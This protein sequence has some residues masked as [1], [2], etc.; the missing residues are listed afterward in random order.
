MGARPIFITEGDPSGISSQLIAK[1]D[2]L[3]RKISKSRPIFLVRSKSNISYSFPEHNV[4]LDSSVDS[5]FIPSSG[6]FQI[7]AEA[8]LQN[9]L[10]IK[11]PSHQSDF[12]LKPITDRKIELGQP[13]KTT[14][15]MS[16]YSLL[17][18]MSLVE[19]FNGDL[20]TLPLSKEWVI[21]S[22]IA[23]FRGHTEALA[24]FF[25]RPTF[26][27]M[28][29][30]KWNVIPLTTHIPIS[31]VSS[32]LKLVAWRKLFQSIIDSKLFPKAC[33][34]GFM[35]LNPHAGEGGKVGDEERKVLKPAMKLAAKMGFQVDGPLPAD[36]TFHLSNQSEW[37]IL[38]A[39]YHDQ[40]LI[41]F[42]LLE[43]KAGINVTLGLPFSRV[44]PDHGP[45][46]SIAA[47]KSKVD[48]LSLNQCLRWLQK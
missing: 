37:D 22:G 16:Y 34:L 32:E 44:S 25:H 40:G 5:S 21:K 42:K 14:G 28:A 43:G 29:G 1:E 3:L 2:S 10:K 48:S 41:P 11:K 18:G 8:F 23:K 45:A 46:Y 26:M 24:E 13:S 27:L 39:S 31:K 38:L 35:G 12:S 7:E 19:K 33:K 17:T 9:S 6:I 20:I 36:S 30:R 15:R 47:S 4:S